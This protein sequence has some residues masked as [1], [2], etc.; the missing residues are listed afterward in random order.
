MFNFLNRISNDLGR[1]MIV[2]CVTVRRLIWLAATRLMGGDCSR[3][4]G[5][6]R[7]I[8]RLFAVFLPSNL[9]GM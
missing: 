8:P 6:R 7:N 9:H 3:F 4:V 2:S 1:C 5:L